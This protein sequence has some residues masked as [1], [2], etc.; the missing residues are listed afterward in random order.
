MYGNSQTTHAPIQQCNL[1]FNSLFFLLSIN[2][3]DS[4][5]ITV[6]IRHICSINWIVST[7]KTNYSILTT[8]RASIKCV[9]NADCDY[10]VLLLDL[11]GFTRERIQF[12]K[13]VLLVCTWS[14]IENGAV[15]NHTHSERERETN[16]I[17]RH[18]IRSHERPMWDE[19]DRILFIR[20]GSTLISF[21][22]LIA[23]LIHWQ[24][25]YLFI[26]CELRC[27]NTFSNQFKKSNQIGECVG[28]NRTKAEENERKE[29]A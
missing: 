7:G 16:W 28:E 12:K 25:F 8:D 21:A 29:I 11:T 6:S 3:M 19:N 10:Y 20:C 22:I 15:A 26:G 14:A 9:Y 18:L 2:H 13:N 4:Y 17:H 27:E 23:T 5:V 1:L 24:N